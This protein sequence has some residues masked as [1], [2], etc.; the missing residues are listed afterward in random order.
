MHFKIMV[1]VERIHHNSKHGYVEKNGHHFNE[2]TLKFAV[3]N[4]YYLDKEGNEVKIPEATEEE[5]LKLMEMYK[6]DIKRYHLYDCLYVLSMGRADFLNSS[7]PDERHLILYVKDLIDD[8]DGYEGLVFNRWC[9]D[10]EGM[11][12]EIDWHEMI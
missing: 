8:P 1:I 2:H 10:L 9:A 7:V 3:N 4:M 12:V 11:N 6:V 5:L